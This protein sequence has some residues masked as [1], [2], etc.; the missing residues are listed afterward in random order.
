MLGVRGHALRLEKSGNLQFPS[1]IPSPW[2]PST[3]SLGT[4]KQVTQASGDYWGLCIRRKGSAHNDL[5][6]CF[7]AGG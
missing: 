5:C 1:Q 6:W 3:G 7:A 4:Q 2:V